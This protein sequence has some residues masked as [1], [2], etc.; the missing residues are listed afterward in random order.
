MTF[1]K[2]NPS[3]QRLPAMQQTNLSFRIVCEAVMGTV[4]GRFITEKS[5]WIDEFKSRRKKSFREYTTLFLTY[6]VR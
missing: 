6:E 5:L 4:A 2:Q 1:Q 3:F